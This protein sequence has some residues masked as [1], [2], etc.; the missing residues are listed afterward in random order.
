MATLGFVTRGHSQ[1]NAN[2]AAQ[3]DNVLQSLLSEVRQLRIA[4]QRANLST[5]LAL[6]AVERMKLQQQRVERLTEQLRGIRDHSANLK[7]AQA[8][9]QYELK[10]IEQRLHQESDVGKR[11]ELEQHQGAIKVRFENMGKEQ[12]RLQEQETQS[13]AHLQTEQTRL[14][15]L[16]DQLD[17]LQRDLQIQAD[18]TKPAQG[19]KR[20]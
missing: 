8:E 1:T 18:E 10:Q 3:G 17:S 12:E 6:T 15:E 19:A 2:Q 4:M 16:N 9:V 13:A 11:A 7:L 14:T 5:Q 20:P